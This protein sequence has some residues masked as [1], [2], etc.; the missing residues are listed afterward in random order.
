MPENHSWAAWPPWPSLQFKIH[1]P[2][3]DQVTQ[4]LQVGT[5][6]PQAEPTRLCKMP[7]WLTWGNT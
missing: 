6:A 4:P 1:P 2:T 7:L 3:W 5:Q